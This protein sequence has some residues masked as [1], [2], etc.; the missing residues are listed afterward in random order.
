MTTLRR[1]PRTAVRHRFSARV[2]N[3]SHGPSGKLGAP[4]ETLLYKDFRT[5]RPDWPPGRLNVLTFR[6]LYVCT[7]CCHHHDDEESTVVFLSRTKEAECQPQR[8]PQG[9]RQPKRLLPPRRLSPRRPAPRSDHRAQGHRSEEDS[10]EEGECG[11]EALA[12]KKTAAKK[13]TAKKTAA[14]TTAKKAPARKA[15]A[16]KIVAKKAP[17]RKTAAKKTTAR[18]RPW[19]RRPR[20]QEDG[21]EEGD[22]PRRPRRRRHRPRRPPPRRRPRS[23]V[24]AKKA[25][26]ARPR[27]RRLPPARPRPARP[28]PGGS[29]AEAG[30]RRRRH[31]TPNTKGH[32]RSSVVPLATCS[33]SLQPPGAAGCQSS[34][35]LGSLSQDS[36]RSWTFSSAR[37][38]SSGELYGPAGR[39][40]RTL[41]WLDLAGLGVVVPLVAVIVA[42][43]DDHLLGVL[44]Q[45][46]RMISPCR[47][48]LLASSRRAAKYPPP[49]RAPNT[50]T[51][52]PRRRT[53]GP[54]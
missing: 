5:F 1:E 53:T 41:V 9:R 2:A 6:V 19:P 26:V 43:L 34:F 27:P 4:P 17:A 20:R 37:A 10:D 31:L 24:A 22:R 32:H 30:R 21:R 39:P 23:K 29:P 38:A 15:A 28:R 50:S 52:P 12:A 18:R 16:K 35:Q 11:E 54:T 42:H 13:A 45:L 33:A 44:S 47:L 48:S 14:K 8:Q 36:L 3:K 25:P 7:K 46:T 49:S 51:S 40:T